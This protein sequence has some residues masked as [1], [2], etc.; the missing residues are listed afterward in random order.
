VFALTSKDYQVTNKIDDLFG[1]PAF[2]KGEVEDRYWRL[3]AAVE[4][5]IKPKGIFDRIMIRELTDKYWE[6]LRYKRGSAA[7]IDSAHVEAL[8][9]LLSPIYQHKMTLTTAAK[10]AVNFYGADPKAKKE[11]TTVMTQYGIT[12][13]MIQAKAI[14][15]IG[16]TLQLLDRMIN[17]REL[18]RRILRKENERRLSVVDN[19][20]A[21]SDS[22]EKVD[23]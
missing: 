23:S 2:I 4:A 1:K 17:N 11:V 7:L 9:S 20:P 12:E 19:V 16:G 21:A 10:A 13:A 14:Q 5:D 6:E 18:S 3:H 22:A 8:A 15:I